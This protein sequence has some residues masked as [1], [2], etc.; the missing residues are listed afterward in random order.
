MSKDTE[1]SFYSGALATYYNN[2]MVSDGLEGVQFRF[3]MEEIVRLVQEAELPS[4]F[5]FSFLVNGSCTRS[6]GAYQATYFGWD[7]FPYR[8]WTTSGRSGRGRGMTINEHLELIFQML[9][10]LE[11]GE[12]SEGTIVNHDPYWRNPDK[13]GIFFLMERC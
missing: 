12:V 1:I 13:R 11:S 9:R 2:P 6:P 7:G 8:C 5:S 10:D 3:D 4:G